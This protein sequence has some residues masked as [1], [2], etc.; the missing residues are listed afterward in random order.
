MSNLTA[1]EYL[2]RLDQQFARQ[3][4]AR[5]VPGQTDEEAQLAL[6]ARVSLALLD[7]AAEIDAYGPRVP[8]ARWPGVSTRRVHQQKICT[9]L[10]TLDRPGKEFEQIRNAYLDV[11]EYYKALLP[12]ETPGV[13]ESPIETASC[14]PEPVFSDSSFRGLS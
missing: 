2:A 7:A 10:L 8:A 11:I 1:P 6:E 13:A 4:T 14:A 12:A 9:Y 5:P 3:L